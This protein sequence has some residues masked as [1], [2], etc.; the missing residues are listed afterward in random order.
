[1]TTGTA[2]PADP[3]T[4]PAPAHTPNAAPA[5][6]PADTTAAKNSTGKTDKADKRGFARREA[7]RTRDGVR[8]LGSVV[9]HWGTAAD[10]GA[11]E[12][13][14]RL[15]A[16]QLDAHTERRTEVEQ[17]LKAA[18]KKTV[19]LEEAAA[20]GGLTQG[21]RQDLTL[22]RE[23]ARRLEKSL[24]EMRKNPFAP[25]QPGERQIEWSRTFTRLRRGAV[26]TAGAIAVIESIVQQPRL[27][28]LELAAAVGVAWWMGSP[29][30]RLAQRQVPAE[31][32]LPELAPPA[33]AQAAPGTE[34]AAA[35]A[36]PLFPGDNG[37]PFPISL[38]GD[39]PAVAGELLR[40]ALV[41]E[42]LAVRAVTDVTREKW[43]W[44]ATAHLT[45][46]RPNDLILR[47]PDLDTS[48]GVR[49]GGVMAQPQASAAG[50]V[51]LRVLQ[52]DPFDPMPPHPVHAPRSNSILQPVDL[53]PSL[54][55]TPTKA[56]LAGQNI[57]VIAVSGGG[58]SQIVRNLVD[59]ITSCTDAIALDIDPTGR[60]FGPLRRLAAQRAYE[61]KRIDDALDWAIREAELRTK[62]MG[63]DVD[64]WQVS[65]DAPA[66]FVIVDEHP[67][68]A[69]TQKAKVIKLSRIGRKARV[70][71]VLLTQDATSDVVGDAVADTFGIRIMLPC[72]K[73]DVPLVVG[74]DTAVS[75]GWMPHRLVP[76]PGDWDP[77][78][79]GC[80]YIIAPGLRD[81]ILR[82][83]T[84][85]VAAVAT[86]RVEE[87]LAAGLAA[88]AERPEHEAAKDAIPEIAA[89]L[90]ATFQAEETEALTLDRLHPHLIEYDS[91]RWDRWKDK[92]PADRL[93]EIGK[94]LGADLRKAG[95]SLPTVRLE[96]LEGSPRGIRR[97]AL[98]AAVKATG[99]ADGDDGE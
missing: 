53:G 93:R 42:G 87:R 85:L 56:T 13:R 92:A 75:E 63:D 12:I 69:K 80:F 8:A 48:L 20:D 11:D 60:G 15:V 51:V 14:R 94:A 43:G 49:T 50:A 16:K 1:M 88:P 9:H 62:Q 78:D 54:D 73:A 5:A 18:L 55:G 35:P 59:Y 45:K 21:Q 3:T 67:Q 30:T 57:M 24:T 29:K 6:E 61:E 82:K 39:N 17:S 79:A 81:P 71:V 74:S 46:G 83:S 31:L 32:L 77:A 19:K 90:L 22:T 4:D 44:K 7:S 99:E 89:V 70:T 33:A 91:E 72:R 23:S 96:E 98:E 36:G 26:L 41:D 68:M 76:S 52:S 64:N 84:H 47:L 97:A 95:L 58:K 10:Q 2:T 25:Q 38:A 65:D 86:Q 37:K 28:L 66:V 34:Q 27:G 40:R